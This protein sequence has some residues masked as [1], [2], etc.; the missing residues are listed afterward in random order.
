MEGTEKGDWDG[1]RRDQLVS[2]CRE[3][4]IGETTLGLSL[5]KARKAEKWKLPDIH[6]GDPN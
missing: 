1:H 6:V 5:E 4:V 2:E 3:R